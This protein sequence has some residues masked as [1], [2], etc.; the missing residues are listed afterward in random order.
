MWK[1]SEPEPIERSEP[2]LK[3][4]PPP[5]VE[6]Q[7][8]PSPVK[9]ARERAVIGPSISIRGEVTG[10]EDLII[11]GRIEGTVNLTRN[12]ST[13]II[14]KEGR[15]KADIHAKVVE[16]EGRVEG[17]LKGDEQVIIRRSANVMGNISAPRVSLEDGCKYRG[18][19][20]MDV[21]TAAT[22]APEKAKVS[23]FKPA[24]HTGTEGATKD[25]FPRP[26]GQQ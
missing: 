9:V 15:V 25:T 26:A 6:P 5:A 3:M 18:T 10:E 11:N 7:R 21:A 24:T 1:K 20:D 19:I 22:R 13:V 2:Q 17:D 12:D 14:G 8:A 16:V 23:D 4:S